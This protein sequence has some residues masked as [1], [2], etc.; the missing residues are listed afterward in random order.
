MDITHETIT[1][2]KILLLWFPLAVMWIFMAVEQPGVNAIIAR[3]SNPKL[4]LAAY[5]VMFPIALIIEAPIIQML[6]AATALT[7]GRRNYTTLLHFMHRWAFGLTVIHLV[8]ALTPLYTLL[9]GSLLGVPENVVEISRVAFII[10]FPW[11]PTI[12]Y[13]RLWQGVLIRY[14]KTTQI[15]YT[16]FIRLFATLGTLFLAYR[17]GWDEG[18]YAGAAALIAGVIAGMVSAYLFARPVI[19]NLEEEAKDKIISRQDLMKFYTPLI[20]TSLITF[21]ARPMLNFGIARA[22]FPLES[23][24]VWPVVLSIMFIF[25]SMALAYQEVAVALLK[26]NADEGLMRS[27][28]VMLSIGTGAAFLVFVLS[29]AGPFWFDTVAGLSEDL[30]P[31]TMLPALLLVCMPVLSGFISWF[32][33]LLIYRGKTKKIAQAVAIN[34]GSLVIMVTVFPLLVDVPGAVLAAA[35]F[36]LSLFFEVIFLAFASRETKLVKAGLK[37]VITDK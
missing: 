10:M 4:N 7:D 24:A 21:L 12:G 19:M 16:M 15:S 28:A 20:L 18:A 31:F 13:R 36:S 37:S 35:V 6:T 23:L 8:V 22:A 26:E 14:G 2:K 27:F 29:P 33:G 5:G 11:T 30:L 25:R 17:L 1:R 34:T 3:L 32:R 9:V